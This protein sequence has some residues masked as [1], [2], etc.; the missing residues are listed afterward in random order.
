MVLDMGFPFPYLKKAL[1]FDLSNVFLVA[2][3]VHGD[4]YHRKGIW[5]TMV[6]G[7]D[8]YALKETHEAAKFDHHRRAK[9]FRIDEVFTVGSFTLYPFLALHNVPCAGF[10]IGHE[11]MKPVVYFTDSTY[12]DT[13]FEGVG[14]YLIESNHDSE[15]V[16][17]RVYAGKM[18]AFLGQR[19]LDDHLSIES[20]EKML[21]NQDLSQTDQIVL[22][23][24]SNFNAHSVNFKNKI[25][26]LTGVPTYIAEK[27][28]SINLSQF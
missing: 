24:L 11:E 12:I 16:T 27:G 20:C 22:L 4:H 28:L 21:M 26:Q 18:N 8:V 13:I 25:Q 2:S 17:D 1:N 3:H 19:V 7:I 10:L 6:S 15:F 23:H 14:T 9:K 5:E